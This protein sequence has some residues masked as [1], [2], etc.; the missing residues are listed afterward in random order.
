M[1]EQRLPKH[2]VVMVT[3]RLK[4]KRKTLYQLKIRNKYSY[5]KETEEEED[6]K[7]RIYGSI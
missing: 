3:R 6:W 4:E 1:E 5:E 2:C 7:D